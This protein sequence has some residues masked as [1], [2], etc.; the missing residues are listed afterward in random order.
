MHQKW[1]RAKNQSMLRR[2]FKNLLLMR[3]YWPDQGDTGDVP[4]FAA[5]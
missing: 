4:A 5:R 2:S 1:C 3:D